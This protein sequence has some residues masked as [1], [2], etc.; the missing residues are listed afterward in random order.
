MRLPQNPALLWMIIIV[1]VITFLSIA[2]YVICTYYAG[3][4]TSEAKDEV[5]REPEDDG[6][7]KHRSFDSVHSQSP[8]PYHTLWSRSDPCMVWLAESV[9]TRSSCNEHGAGV[10]SNYNNT[11]HGADLSTIALWLQTHCLSPP[12]AAMTRFRSVDG[13]L[14]E[15]RGERAS[16]V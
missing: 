11:E 2:L 6:W 9:E 14:M 10:E 15:A 1:G 8:P 3:S 5:A 7:Y 16:I 12:P 13:L 4:P